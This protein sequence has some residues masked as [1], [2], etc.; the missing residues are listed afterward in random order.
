MNM[1][2]RSQ[3]GAAF[4]VI[5]VMISIGIFAMV[6][7]A[8]YATWMAIV[9]G[10]RVAQNAAAS[11]QRAR[12]AVSALEASFRTVQLFTDNIQAYAF[13]TDT[14]GDLAAVSMV[15]RLSPA[16]PGFGVH[17]GLEMCRISFYPQPASDGSYEL[18][19]THA[20]MLAD[21]N[22][23][24]GEAYSAVLAKDVTLFTVEFWDRQKNEYITEWLYTNQLPQKVLISFASGK[25][26]GSSP[27]AE[28]VVVK[29][30]VIPSGAY[31]GLQAGGPA[32]I[33]PQPPP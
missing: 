10:S 6:I 21:T 17:R 30:V 4:T 7:T 11:V 28:D 1:S 25:K 14:S 16:I 20:P 2:Q 19:M 3:R 18:V 5:E 26:T 22:H 27:A 15:S 9:K 8:I 23:P 24:Q 12:I 31:I 32:G 29:E 33:R 13:L